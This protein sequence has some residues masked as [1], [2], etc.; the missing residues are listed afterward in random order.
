M[1]RVE[2]RV[3]PTTLLQLVLLSH[4]AVGLVSEEVRPRGR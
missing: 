1:A 2:D 3:R 4:Q